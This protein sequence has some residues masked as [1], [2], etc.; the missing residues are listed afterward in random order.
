VLVLPYWILFSVFALGSL[1]GSSPSQGLRRHG[2]LLAVAGLL[3]ALFIG[4]RFE[5]GGDWMN[6]LGIYQE[7]GVQSL[8][9]ALVS[10]R[11]DP[12]YSLIN[13]I[14][15]QAGAELWVVN[16]VCGCIMCWGV[17]KFA[18]TQPSPWLVMLVAI[19]YLIIVV[20]MGYT[21]QAVAIAF[22]LVAISAF[23]SGSILRFLI[24]GV[25]AVTFHKSAIVFFPLVGLAITRNRLIVT[26]LIAMA[27]AILY[28][29][30]V[31]Q[32]VGVLANNYEALESH[33]AGV[34]ILMNVIP[35]ILFLLFRRRFAVAEHESKLWRNLAFA[36]LATGAALFLTS[37][38]TAID[39]LALYLI[40]LQLFVFGRLP[41]AF[42][43]GRRPLPGYV[44]AVIAYSAAVQFVWLS[45]G[46]NARYWIPYRNWLFIDQEGV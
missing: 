26:L 2:L 13:W 38:S 35:G 33:G 25:I 7:L 39:R 5:T 14:A 19:P 22:E 30:V 6:Y 34:R 18:N 28:W 8:P 12:S 29:T 31:S 24:Y 32:R 43:S 9:D 37:A 1:Q 10:P 41:V 4:L 3:A 36:A 27:S 17:V 15:Y 40:P 23:V 45:Y 16:L 20:G 46:D 11:S 44:I 42:S 21:R